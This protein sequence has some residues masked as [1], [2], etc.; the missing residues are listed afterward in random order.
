MKR[1]NHIVVGIFTANLLGLPIFPAMFASVLPDI[2][3]KWSQPFVDRGLFGSHR[4]IT[5]HA[6]IGAIFT[7]LAIWFYFHPSLVHY[8]IASFFVGYVS[9]LLADICTKSGI[10][11]WKNRNRFSLRLFATGDALEYIFVWSIVAL[12]SLVMLYLEGIYYFVPADI[13]WIAKLFHMIRW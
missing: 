9:H 1:N 2:D 5:H 7:T 13:L 6:I 12:V 11:Y 3:T 10:P 8:T 4:G